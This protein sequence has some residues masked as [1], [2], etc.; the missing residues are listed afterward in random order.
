MKLKSYLEK[1]KVSL[2]KFALDCGIDHA[3]LWRL[4]HGMTKS[5]RLETVRAIEKITNGK[6]TFRDFV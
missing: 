1:E 3:T 4:V 6:V 5:P 2:T